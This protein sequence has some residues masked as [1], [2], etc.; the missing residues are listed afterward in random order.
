MNAAETQ[1][2]FVYG[3]VNAKRKFLSTRLPD[4][5]RARPALTQAN[6]F[7]NKRRLFFAKPRKLICEGIL[8]KSFLGDKTSCNEMSTQIR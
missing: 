5:A 2:T 7:R 8:A 6:N 4:L 1:V 3:R